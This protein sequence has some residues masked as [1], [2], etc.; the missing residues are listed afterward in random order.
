M[1]G[2]GGGGDISSSAGRIVYTRDFAPGRFVKKLDYM[3][4]PGFLDGSPDA[5]RKANLVGGG[6]SC[7]V[8]DRGV[9]R[10]DPETKEVYLAEIFPWQDEKD[11]EEIKGLI[12]WDLKVAKDLKVIEPPTERELWAMKL[13]DP[14]GMWTIPN[15]MDRPV[16]KILASG[17]F[18]YEGYDYLLGLREAGWRKAMEYLV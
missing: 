12:E 9:L 11:I 17:K 14:D 13:M 4:N 5:R 6:P 1:N 8:T 7:I 16:G 10:F 18:D 15:M 3:T 2:S